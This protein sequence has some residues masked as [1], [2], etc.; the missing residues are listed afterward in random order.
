VILRRPAEIAAGA[1]LGALVGLLIG[2]SSTPVV[3]GVISALV[4]LLVAFFGLLEK[5]SPDGM[6]TLRIASFAVLCF[7]GVVLGI[8]SR[9]HEWFSPSVHTRIQKWVGAGYSP[10][11]ARALTAYESLGVVPKGQSVV[12]APK[13]LGS[14]LF[15]D[16]NFSE[17]DNLMPSHYR[18]GSDQVAAMQEA[19]PQW[20]ALADSIYELNA[21]TQEAVVKAAYRLACP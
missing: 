11:E 8:V 18:S 7:A 12:E 19:G 9:A 15:S 10:E 4:G 20:K 17:C 13:A 5:S 14:L 2:L 16:K 21:T 3:A 6:K 1:S